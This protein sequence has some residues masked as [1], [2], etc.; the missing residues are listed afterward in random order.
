MDNI[1]T[2]DRKEKT[3]ETPIITIGTDINLGI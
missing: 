3:I 2:V 1:R